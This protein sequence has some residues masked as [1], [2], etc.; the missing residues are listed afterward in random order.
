MQYCEKNKTV[1][2]LKDLIE[3]LKSEHNDKFVYR[4]QNQEF[5][6]LIPSFYR[7]LVDKHRG[8]H[9]NGYVSLFNRGDY[10]YET[11]TNYNINEKFIKRL[12]FLKLSLHLFGIPLGNLFCQ[13]CGVPT[14]GL[15]V[16]K[17]IMVAALFA[18][19]NYNKKKYVENS[20]ANGVIYRIDTKTKKIDSLSQVKEFDSFDCPFYLDGTSILS[21]INNCDSIEESI[22]SYKEY[23]IR[24]SYLTSVADIEEKKY[25]YYRPIELLKLPQ[26]ELKIGRVFKQKA[27]L[28]FPDFLIDQIEDGRTFPHFEGKPWRG[29]FSIEDLS[30]CINVERFLFYHVKENEKCINSDPVEIFPKNDPIK[31]L[32]LNILTAQYGTPIMYLGVGP[33][34]F[35]GDEDD[36]FT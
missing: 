12:N 33:I 27:G 1:W 31:S 30:K 9:R 24:H 22:N 17:D 26:N 18:I 10:F 34:L 7:S 3:K 21:L 19:Y 35:P 28:I 29:C 13:H 23:Q 8:F 6:P 11:Y 4:G 20:N 16:T 36:V 2:Y 25:N 32:M 5:I 14:E 15:D